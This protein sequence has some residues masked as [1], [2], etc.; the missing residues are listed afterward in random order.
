MQMF[1]QFLTLF[2]AP[3]IT[4]FIL[5]SSAQ[6]GLPF[7]A[8][9]EK[10]PSLAPILERSTPAVVNILTRSTVKVRRNPLLDDPFF[11]DFFNL[12]PQ[13][14]RETQGLGSGVI[15]DA[16][17]G[18]ILTNNHVIAGAD[19]IT[20]TLRDG[21]QL[22]AKLIG[23]DPDT[24]VAVLKVQADNLVALPFANSE[25]L[26]VGDFV[27]AIGN[28]FGLGQTVTSGIVSALDR[29]GL[30][31]GRFEDYIQTDASINPGNSGGA[32]IDLRGQLIGINNAIYSRTG[33]N[34]GIGFAIP[35]NMARDIMDQLIET[36]SVQRGRL[37]AQAQDLTPELAQAFKLKTGTRGAVVVN[38]ISGSPADRAGLRVGDVIRAVNKQPV[39]K[40]DDLHNAI[41]LLRVG[42]KVSLTVLRDSKQRVISAKI[43]K[44]K[45]T[46]IDAGK[47]HKRLSGA[48]F[49]NLAEDHPA[50]GKLDGIVI[51]RVKPRSPAAASGLRK[52][53]IITRINRQA[54]NSPAQAKQLASKNHRGIRLSIIRGRSSLTLVL[55]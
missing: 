37:G 4:L 12:Q 48:E 1:R 39:H 15:V 50:Y 38:V 52:G 29:S 24:D 23:T 36:G 14:K 41:G 13:R 21:R 49:S 19:I 8:D 45:R 51:S 5:V 20:V 31:I 22:D 28:P 3:F 2:S 32:L 40:A 30:G 42:T 26:R 11:K 10:L 47:L 35:I 33:S 17:K 46:T 18:Y 16:K 43:A 27:I 25:K 34:I 9:G 6:A 44:T 7:S 53:D 54:V 55:Q